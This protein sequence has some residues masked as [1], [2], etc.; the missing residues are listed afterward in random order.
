MF[1]QLRLPPLDEEKK[2]PLGPD[3]ALAEAHRCLSCYDAP[4]T[5]ACPTHI[6]VPLF[7]KQIGSGNVLGA[8]R[9]ILAANILGASCARVCP[10]EVLCEGACV[11]S[12]EHRPIAIGLLQRHATDHAMARGVLP[13]T[14][15]QRG[16]PGPSPSGGSTGII[17]GGPAGLACAAELLALGHAAVIYEAADQPGGLN[18]FGVAQYK[19]APEVARREVEWLVR[20][21]VTIAC[22]VRVGRDVSLA[23]LEARH[24]ALFVGVGMGA[25]PPLSIPG[26]DLPGVLDALD[27]IADLKLGRPVRGFVPGTGAG[28]G[29][30]PLSGARVAVIGGGNT[31]IDATTQAAR[32]GAA[33]VFLV[34]RRGQGE[35]SAYAHE[36]E[37]AWEHGVRPFFWSAPLRVLGAGRV[38]GLAIETVRAEGGEA[39]LDRKARLV[40]VPGT[41]RVLPVDVV[42]RATGQRGADLL[43]QLAGVIPASGIDARRGTLRVNEW[44]QTENPRYFAGGDCISGGKEV[45]NA[46][47]EGKR[48]AQGIARLMDQIRGQKGQ[49]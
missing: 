17:G 3:A 16:N 4:C 5:R 11:L 19:M 20:A 6:D 25:V 12:D 37:L 42:V 39:R 40:S 38:E 34:Y 26:E 24:D 10:T 35:M 21:G 8:A 7:I 14:A 23:E 31:A 46:V 2:P 36:Q 32:A 18:T 28:S 48:A 41:E 9:T 45:V 47:A 22:G 33:E 49:G 43:A 29:G 44:G 13:F 27:L 30:G 1:S 15:R